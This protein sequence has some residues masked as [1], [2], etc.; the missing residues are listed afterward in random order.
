M[1]EF[2]VV[3]HLAAAAVY[4][5]LAGFTACRYLRRGIDRALFLAASLTTVWAISIVAQSL[6]GW[7][8]F[9]LRYVTELARNTAWI[10]VLF[11]LIRDARDHSLFSHRMLLFASGALLTI[12]S[13]L[14]ASALTGWALDM[15]LLS[16]R[17]TLFAQLAISL[18]GVSVLEQIWRNASAY[19]RSSI[20]Y[21][22]FG[23]T[24]IFLYEFLLYADALLFNRMSSGL[25]DA[26]GAV[27]ALLTPL[28]AVNLINARRQPVQLQLSRTFVYHA[29]TLIF[30]GIYLLIVA[31]GGYY[32]RLAGGEWGEGL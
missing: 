22:C 27:N 21:L 20:R 32:V 9:A 25:W 10:L 3:S 19:G 26:R 2:G 14:M 18:L 6:W 13:V 12:L 7:P 1:L 31:I 16:T 29:G 11:A 15:S 28:F 30:G 4:A 17:A 5:F 24:G 8:E 23:I